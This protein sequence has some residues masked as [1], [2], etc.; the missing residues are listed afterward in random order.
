[1]GYGFLPLN[2]G[3]MPKL[4]AQVGAVLMHHSTIDAKTS[5]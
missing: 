1:M 2:L 3:K 4:L 5:R